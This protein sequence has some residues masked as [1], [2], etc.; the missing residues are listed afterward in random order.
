[1]TAGVGGEVGASCNRDCYFDFGNGHGEGD[2]R[3]DTT[4]D[5]LAPDHQCAYNEAD[6]NSN[7]CPSPQAD[8]CFARCRPLTPNGCD[9][10]GCCTFDALDGRSE[11]D[12]GEFVWLG[13]G[14]GMGE[15]GEGTCTLEDI[16]DTELCKPCTP[17]MECFNDCGRCELCVGRDT[18]PDDC[19]NPPP[20]PVD[21][22]VPD[23]EVPDG[24][25]PDA[26]TP[27]AGMYEPRC[28]DGIQPCGL[29]GDAECEE[30]HYCVT[31]CC[32]SI[33]I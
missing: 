33:L 23:A 15:D 11:D 18:I 7:R 26:N 25:I 14:I 27:D 10:F 4:C 19:L 12:G 28:D 21:A 30:F 3:W 1:M 24:A 22:A 17:Q 13:S 32:Q 20:P 9:C 6:L 8:N 31:G 5:P 2:C 16:E 29:E